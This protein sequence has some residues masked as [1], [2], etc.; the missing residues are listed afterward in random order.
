[1]FLGLFK[2]LLFTTAFFLP[3][4]AFSQIES[5]TI[6]V[7]GLTCSQCSRS[8]E[9]ALLKL[10]FVDKVDMNLAHT[11]GV[12]Y[13]KKGDPVDLQKLAQ[14]PRDAGFSTRF[15]KLEFNTSQ[16]QSGQ[17]CFVYRNKV[18]YLLQPFTK[19]NGKGSLFQ[20]IAKGFLPNKE[21]RNYSLKPKGSCSA[22]EKYYLKPVNG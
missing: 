1:M 8:V 19:G 17:N 21:W 9:M 10:P 6:G 12:V 2:K 20:V 18:F 14:A 22:Q 13:F 16:I 5:A 11:I 7:D 15:V 3:T 4:L